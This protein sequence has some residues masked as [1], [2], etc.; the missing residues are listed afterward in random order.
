MA[1]ERK[2]ETE[3]CAWVAIWLP[4]RAEAG[5]AAGRNWMVMY[6]LGFSFLREKQLSAW[7]LLCL[8]LHF[9]PF[10]GCSSCVVGRARCHSLVLLAKDDMDFQPQGQQWA[11]SQNSHLLPSRL[12]MSWHGLDPCWSL[13][14]QG[15][16]WLFTPSARR[17]PRV[18]MQEN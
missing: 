7:L 14:T 5:P 9:Q 17:K 3:K 18:F 13:P 4:G 1:A 15:I 8:Q 10:L 12:L 6:S 2:K 11:G 16:L